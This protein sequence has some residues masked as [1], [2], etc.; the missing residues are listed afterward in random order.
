MCDGPA[1]S[2]S[3]FD[4]SFRCETECDP[5]RGQH[6]VT[7]TWFGDHFRTWV[8]DLDLGTAVPHQARHT[9]AT[10]LLAAG[11]SM[12]HIKRFLGHVSERMTEHY[13][14]VALSEID[15]VL[16]HV[17]VAGPGSHNPGEMLSRGVTPLPREQAQALVLDL[18]RRSTPTD[19]GICTYQI[20]VDGAP[21]RGSWTARTARN[22]S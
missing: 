14:K 13:A 9:L 6:N 2:R 21:A 16:H 20:V 18:N 7:Y 10:K 12:Q 5:A 11:A 15:E 3:L 8:D 22:S 19:G 17:W 4:T 1:A